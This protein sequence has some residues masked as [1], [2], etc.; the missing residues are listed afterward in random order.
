MKINTMDSK[1]ILILFDLK[2]CEH[3]VYQLVNDEYIGFLDDKEKI[4]YFEG[5]ELLLSSQFDINFYSKD[6]FNHLIN[7]LN[8]NNYEKVSMFKSFHYIKDDKIHIMKNKFLDNWWL[9][10]DLIIGDFKSEITQYNLLMLSYL[11][12]SILIKHYNQKATASMFVN[13]GELI[14]FLNGTNYEK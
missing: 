4:P 1:Y 10:I 5:F 6:L 7:V 13:L 2:T 8:I 3:K 12:N 14:K 9:D 11:V